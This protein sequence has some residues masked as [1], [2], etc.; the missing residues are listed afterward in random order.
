MYQIQNKFFKLEFGKA[1]TELQEDVFFDC[2][3]T[4]V[5]PQRVMVQKIN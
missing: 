4:E 2:Q 3:F 5:V 1:L